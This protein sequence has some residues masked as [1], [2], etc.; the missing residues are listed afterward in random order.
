MPSDLHEHLC[1]RGA[2]WCKKQG[3]PIIATGLKANSSREQP[4]VIAF[5]ADCS[6]IIE[7]KASR[8]DFFKDREKPER[9]GEGLG[10][11]RFYIVP[12]GLVQVDEV[13]DSWGLLEVTGKKI[14]ETKRPKGN[15][16]L[17][18][19]SKACLEWSR[20]QNP[21]DQQAER[22]MLFTIARRAVA[23]KSILN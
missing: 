19:N 15:L 23:G 16:W 1:D 5:R 2:Q 20:F 4:D 7:A 14:L 22:A 11:Y 9:K 3:F 6:L 13:P 12:S 17:S 18:Q 21:V 8:N 10:L